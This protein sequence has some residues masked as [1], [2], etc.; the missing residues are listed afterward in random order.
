MTSK[1]AAIKKKNLKIG[2]SM[3]V[4]LMNIIK[5][6]LKTVILY[7]CALIC[8]QLIALYLKKKNKV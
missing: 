3:F 2:K 4:Y 6:K 5:L 7:F 8:L 1:W